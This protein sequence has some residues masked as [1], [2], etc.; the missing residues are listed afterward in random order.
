M[1]ED[2]LDHTNCS[3]LCRKRSRR[4]NSCLGAEAARS[5]RN[6]VL[7]E[8]K[9]LWYLLCILEVG[10]SFGEYADL[11]DSGVLRFNPILELCIPRGQR[12]L[13]QLSK[14]SQELLVI[15]KAFYWH[16]D[17]LINNKRHWEEAP[18][19]TKLRMKTGSMARG[20][21]RTT[22]DA[23]K[24]LLLPKKTSVPELGVMREGILT[25]AWSISIYWQVVAMQ[26]VQASRKMFAL[27]CCRLASRQAKT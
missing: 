22:H 7:A 17:T 18:Q 24:F 27:Y 1:K 26:Q 20:R 6:H 12:K 16:N 9:S 15:A 19:K 5:T 11:V 4:G 23:L 21:H 14:L 25:C 10:K 13:Y 2:P 3:L 8:S